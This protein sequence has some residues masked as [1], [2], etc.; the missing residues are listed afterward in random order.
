MPRCTADKMML[1][2]NLAG[3][4]TKSRRNRLLN[5]TI[6]KDFLNSNI[7]IKNIFEREGIRKYRDL[8]RSYE[9]DSNENY[10][11]CY[12]NF[13]HQSME[14]TDRHL[15][16]KGL[17]SKP[18]YII[19]SDLNKTQRNHVKILEKMLS[20]AQTRDYPI[21]INLGVIRL[22]G[23]DK[24]LSIKKEDNRTFYYVNDMIYPAETGSLIKICDENPTKIKPMAKSFVK[25]ISSY[26]ADEFKREY[27]EKLKRYLFNS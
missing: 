6:D 12:K 5:S 11:A 9:D 23:E 8:I 1:E 17:I 16:E 20:K 4:L 19:W 2:Y 21:K 3:K 10:I 26:K 18:D 15:V 22:N 13:G 14:L 7:R 25:K 24:D 27:E